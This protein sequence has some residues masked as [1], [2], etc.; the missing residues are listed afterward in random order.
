ML[1]FD[2]LG[3]RFAFVLFAFDLQCGSA[4]VPVTGAGRCCEWRLLRA[5]CGGLLARLLP[6]LL[7]ALFYGFLVVRFFLVLFAFDLQCGSAGVPVTG[8]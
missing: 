2:P 1:F 8:A 4:V 7:F 6:A 5:G 3:L